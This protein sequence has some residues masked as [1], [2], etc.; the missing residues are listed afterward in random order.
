MMHRIHPCFTQ[1]PMESKTHAG[2]WHDLITKDSCGIMRKSSMVP[3]DTQMLDAGE[4]NMNRTES[5]VVMDEN[6]DVIC[7]ASQPTYGEQFMGATIK[8]FL[9]C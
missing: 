7:Q 1:T 9:F 4:A 6:A 5:G 8:T 2:D 3:E